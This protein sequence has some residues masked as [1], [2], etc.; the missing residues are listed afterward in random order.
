MFG[1]GFWPG[2]SWFSTVLIN[3]LP[4]PV[5]AGITRYRAKNTN[6]YRQ[7]GAALK[8]LFGKWVW[9]QSSGRWQPGKTPATT[10]Y[11]H[12]LELKDNGTVLIWKN[13]EL[14]GEGYFYTE[15]PKNP[16]AIT[17]KY[18]TR[19]KVSHRL[20]VSFRFVGKNTL[21]LTEASRIKSKQHLFLRV[22]PD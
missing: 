1:V 15:D 13:E 9:L 10:G 20:A 5:V 2:N 22:K 11:I 12:L 6:K 4:R 17:L 8:P 7:P 16:Q 19:N 18:R 21:C 14:Y 3:A